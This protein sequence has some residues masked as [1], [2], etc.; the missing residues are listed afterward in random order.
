MACSMSYRRAAAVALVLTGAR[1]AMGGDGWPLVDQARRRNGSTWTTRRS[2]VTLQSFDGQEGRTREATIVEKTSPTGPHSTLIEFTGPEDI[3]G[4]RLLHV[5]PRGVPDQYWIWQPQT[6]RARHLGGNAGGSSHRD[7]IMTGN[8]MS[9][10]D[11]ELV[12]RIQQWD[13]S[14]ATATLEGDEPCADTE[15]SRVA[16]VPNR[17][18]EFPCKRYRL[19]YSHG[20][21]QLR[22]VDLYDLDDQV[23]KRITCSDYFPTGAV[24]TPRTCVIE[25]VPSKVR[26]VIT[27]REVA[28]DEPVDDDVFSLARLSEGR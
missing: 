13:S 12:V 22:R 4:T 7:E 9:Y 25:H 11:L 1:L 6:R 20:D 5:S 17:P 26:S 3:R 10:R 21:L 15:C 23:V 24:Q 8:D 16:L 14:S 27:V 2:S 28:Y 18:N 19:W